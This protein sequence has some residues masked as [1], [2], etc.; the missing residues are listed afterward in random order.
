MQPYMALWLTS[1]I[2]SDN[3]RHKSLDKFVQQQNNHQ[4]QHQQ[5]NCLSLRIQL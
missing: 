1:S 3:I 5:S 4:N 2:I